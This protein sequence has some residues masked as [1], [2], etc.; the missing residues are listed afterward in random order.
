MSG[1]LERLGRLCAR[2]HTYV[3]VVWIVAAV[4]IVGLAK[5]SGGRTFDNFRIPH[6]ESQKAA[7]L[8]VSRFPQQSGTSAT[9][10]FQA[11]TGTVADPAAQRAIE[12]SVAALQKLPHASQVVGPVGPFASALT[13]KN[14]TI[15]LATVQYAAQPPAIGT[16]GFHALQAAAAPA[17]LSLIHI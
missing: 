9:V 1:F 3:I 11:R 15:G 8:L 4:A 13:S 14:G 10:V 5:A 6:A 12:A 16:A 7:D 17:K 2:R